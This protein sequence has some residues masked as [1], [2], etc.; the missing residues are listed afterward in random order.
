MLG[1]SAAK[2]KHS[3]Q[4]DLIDGP[5]PIDITILAPSAHVESSWPEPD[6]G[7]RWN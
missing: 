2:D 4:D 6:G 5:Y 7:R 3:A 1:P